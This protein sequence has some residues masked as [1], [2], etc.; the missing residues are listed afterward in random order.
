MRYLRQLLTLGKPQWPRL[1]EVDVDQLIADAAALVE[2][3]FRHRGVRLKVKASAGGVVL[4]QADAE[5]LRQALVNLLLNAVEAAGESGWTALACDTNDHE[6]RLTV[7]DGGPGPPPE[8]AA[9]LFEPFVTSK[10]DGVGLGLAASRRIVEQHGGTLTFS[11][12]P[13]TRFEIRLP[14]VAT[15]AADAPV[16]PF[17]SAAERNHA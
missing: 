1:S 7:S 3:T 11:A 14:R 15:A 17:V 4:P 12:A 6:V 5:L 10:P 16:R 13:H 9:R 8:V 2:P